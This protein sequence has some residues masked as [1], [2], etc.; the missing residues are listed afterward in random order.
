MQCRKASCRSTLHGRRL[1]WSW[2]RWCISEWAWSRIKC[3]T[4]EHTLCRLHQYLLLYSNPFALLSAMALLR[5]LL[6]LSVVSWVHAAVTPLNPS[7]QIRN[8]P[9]KSVQETYLAIKSGL[10]AAS[11]DKRE[12]FKPAQPITLERSWDGATLLSLYVI[13][14]P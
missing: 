3:S 7:V 10:A 12:S 4:S 9:G 5:T 1:L 8:A 11:L 2:E 13:H 14:M 6:F